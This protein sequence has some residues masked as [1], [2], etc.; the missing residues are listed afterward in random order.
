MAASLLWVGRGGVDVGAVMS[1]GADSGGCEAVP[2]CVFSGARASRGG[3]SSRRC[4]P[5]PTVGFSRVRALRSRGGALLATRDALPWL[6]GGLLPEL[7]YHRPQRGWHPTRAPAPQRL[8]RIVEEVLGSHTRR[9]QRAR[10]EKSDRWPP[11]AAPSLGAAP[12]VPLRRAPSPPDLRVT[13]GSDG[14]PRV[15]LRLRRRA[16]GR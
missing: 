10:V 1:F 15:H 2:G 7:P 14:P 12:G 8:R 16:D 13:T 3:R 6:G 9:G 4:P 5:K 11:R